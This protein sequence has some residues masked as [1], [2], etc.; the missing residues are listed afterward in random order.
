MVMD[1][2]KISYEKANELLKEHGSVR[3][4]V[5]SQEK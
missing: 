1:A 3:K 4:A 5:D 2:L